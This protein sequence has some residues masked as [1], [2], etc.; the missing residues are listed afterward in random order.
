MAPHHQPPR[1]SPSPLCAGT[2]RVVHADTSASPQLQKLAASLGLKRFPAL[3]AFAEGKEVLRRQGERLIPASLRH[4]C[5]TLLLSR[6]P[7]AGTVPHTPAKQAE[8]DG[9]APSLA[10][11]SASKAIEQSAR[12]SAPG[13]TLP[14]AA[15]A[16]GGGSSSPY[17]EASSPASVYDPPEARLAK[18]GFTRRMPD[19]ETVHYFPKMPCLRYVWGPQGLHLARPRVE[20]DGGIDGGPSNMPCPLAHPH[21]VWLPM[22]DV[23]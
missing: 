2:V 10:P 12:V 19:G 22:V 1:L 15:A 4:T 11:A 14:A 21:Q 17:P 5:V 16:A 23:R 13:E 9:I 18:P 20:K 6:P 8:E 3:L 7:A